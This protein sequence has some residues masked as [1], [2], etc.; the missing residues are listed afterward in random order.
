MHFLHLNRLLPN[1]ALKAFC[2]LKNAFSYIYILH[3]DIQTETHFLSISINRR[4]HLSTCFVKLWHPGRSWHSANHFCEICFVW[5]E[6][7]HLVFQLCQGLKISAFHQRKPILFS[8]FWENT[9]N[10][11]QLLLLL[12]SNL[13][14]DTNKYSFCCGTHY[15]WCSCLLII[16]RISALSPLYSAANYIN[17]KD[18]FW[19]M[20]HCWKAKYSTLSLKW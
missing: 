20:R 10:Q 2:R 5:I 19:R 1:S 13:K 9:A 16:H 6:A 11:F 18:I 7:I 15:T 4:A 14:S 8:M 12:I 17:F 3:F